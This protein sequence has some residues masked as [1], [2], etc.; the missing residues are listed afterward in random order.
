MGLATSYFVK[1][2]AQWCGFSQK[3]R[4]FCIIRGKN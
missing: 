2:G 3:E 1:E 4:F